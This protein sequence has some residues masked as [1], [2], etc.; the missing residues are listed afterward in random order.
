VRVVAIQI[1]LQ[2]W[3]VSL[4]KGDSWGCEGSCHLELASRVGWGLSKN[5]QQMQ[6]KHR[7]S[8]WINREGIK[9]SQ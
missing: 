6:Q 2:G 3:G 7:E 1:L 5:R 4:K 8:K 9:R